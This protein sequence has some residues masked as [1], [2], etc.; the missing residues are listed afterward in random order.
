MW[1]VR[2]REKILDIGGSIVFFKEK[3]WIHDRGTDFAGVT[4]KEG[5]LVI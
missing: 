5:T 3:G 1:I 2:W 4:T